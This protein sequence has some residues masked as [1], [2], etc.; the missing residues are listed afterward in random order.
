MPNNFIHVTYS[1]KI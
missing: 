1:V